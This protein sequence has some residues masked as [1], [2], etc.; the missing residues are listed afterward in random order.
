MAQV[1]KRNRRRNYRRDLPHLSV[2]LTGGEVFITRDWS[3]G[4]LR[5]D[6][7]ATTRQPG[8]PVVGSLRHGAANTAWHRFIGS[9]VRIDGDDTVAIRFE[10]LS[11]GCFELLQ[12]L[13]RRPPPDEP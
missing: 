6:G 10:D 1:I 3:L 12:S 2:Q 11:P 5:I 9:V 7:L 13:L 4:G 8:E